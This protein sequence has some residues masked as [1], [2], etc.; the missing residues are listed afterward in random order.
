MGKL[1]LLILS[2]IKNYVRTIVVADKHKLNQNFAT[3]HHVYRIYDDYHEMMEKEDLDGVVISLPN[4]LKEES[5]SFACKNRIPYIFI[6]KPLARS[7]DEAKRIC[8]KVYHANAK[9]MVGVNCRYMDCVRKIVESFY[10]GCVGE[11]RI[12][13][14]ELI[15]NGPFT[16]PLTPRPVAEWWLSPELAGGGALLDLGYHHLD[17]ACS[18]FNELKPVFAELKYTMNLPVEDTATVVLSTKNKKV[19]IILN[20]G[21]FSKTIFPEYNFRIDIYGTAG[22]LSTS[23]FIPKNIYYHAIKTG[24][25]N[26]LRKLVGREIRYLA[27]TYYYE[28]YVEMIKDFLN[29]IQEEKD[30]SS[31]LKDQLKVLEI[32]DFIYKNYYGRS[33]K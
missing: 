2:R 25:L 27:Y 3:Q 16:H 6:D 7:L 33:H 29:S 30:F 28:S 20:V 17:I 15:T 8:D 32:I 26:F 24:F 5:V 21:W 23:S 11:A 13:V 4:F 14:F 31:L 12:S 19:T 1:Y 22:H 10:E 9:L 18:L